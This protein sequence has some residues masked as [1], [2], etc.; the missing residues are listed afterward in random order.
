METALEFME[1]RFY[2][3]GYM[4][5]RELSYQGDSIVFNFQPVEPPVTTHIKYFTPR[6][7]HL[8]ISQ[9]TYAFL[10]ELAKNNQ[11]DLNHDQL[12]EICLAGRLK[13][14]EMSFRFRREIK[15][16][17][18]L[19]GKLDLTKMRLGKMP[20]LKMDFDIE[21]RSLTGSLTGLI[22]PIPVPQINQ[23]VARNN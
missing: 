4:C 22:S 7:L 21:D 15:L 23:D 13:L 5:L 1:R 19:S 2:L 6:G 20:L 11:V 12:R 17:K 9:G 14:V 18:N 3:P 10:E 16:D 8:A